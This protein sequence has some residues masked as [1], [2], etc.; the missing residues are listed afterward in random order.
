MRIMESLFPAHRSERE[1]L[2]VVEQEGVLRALAAA[3]AFSS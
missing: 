3:Q 2:P 1:P